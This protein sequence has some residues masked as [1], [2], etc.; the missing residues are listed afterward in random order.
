MLRAVG[1]DYVT[2]LVKSKVQARVETQPHL[3]LSSNCPAVT[4]L[5][6]ESFAVAHA[7]TR[8]DPGSIEGPR[9]AK[10]AFL[11]LDLRHEVRTPLNGLFGIGDI[12]FSEFGLPPP[13]ENDLRRSV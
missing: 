8:R 9:Q 5:P 4:H 10:S 1:V 13:Q 12:P 3:I 7:R 2:N 6:L 11:Q